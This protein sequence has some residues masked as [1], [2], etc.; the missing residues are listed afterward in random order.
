[1]FNYKYNEI[2]PRVVEAENAFERFFLEFESVEQA[3]DW[4]T[5]MSETLKAVLG[6]TIGSKCEVCFGPLQPAYC[7]HCIKCDRICCAECCGYINS[8]DRKTSSK[9]MACLSC[10]EYNENILNKNTDVKALIDSRNSCNRENYIQ[11]VFVCN[12]AKK[13]ELKLPEGWEACITH[14]SRVYYLNRSLWLSSW[15]LPKETFVNDAPYGWQKYYGEKDAGFYY[16]SKGHCVKF[17][18]PLDPMK[19]T[20]G[21]PDCDY[22][23]TKNDIV[24]GVC[25][26]CNTSLKVLSSLYVC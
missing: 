1:M 23:P 16:Q 7:C 3:Q 14:D 6:R 9:N 22:A 12:L 21:C 15:S 2:T 8:H 4:Y 18:R 10:L 20:V 11:P 26:C 17:D 25:P 24:K 13:Q 5:Q 19:A